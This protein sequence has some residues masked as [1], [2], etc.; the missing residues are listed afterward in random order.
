MRFTTLKVNRCTCTL[1]VNRKAKE[2]P[3]QCSIY[4]SVRLMR[5]SSRNFNIP[6]PGQGPATSTFED[7]IVQIPGPCGQNSVE[8]PYPIFGFVYQMP[9]L[10]NTRRRLLS[11]LMK[12]LYIC[13]TGRH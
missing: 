9:L 7:W 12:L 6:T 3:Q 8:M 13:G 10:K 1:K 4:C 2:L 5:R 11:S